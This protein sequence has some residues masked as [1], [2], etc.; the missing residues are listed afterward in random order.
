[1]TREYPFTFK[2]QDKASLLVFAGQQCRI[3]KQAGKWIRI[4]FKSG[5]QIDAKPRWLKRRRVR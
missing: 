1:M 2:Q 5:Y 3:I 4:E